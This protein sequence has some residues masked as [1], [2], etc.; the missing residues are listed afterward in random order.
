MSNKMNNPFIKSKDIAKSYHHLPSFIEHLP[1]SDFNEKHKL[2]LLEDHASLGVCFKITPLSCEARPEKMLNE[3]STAIGEA[4]KNAI[5]C[6]K[7]HPWILQ[8]YASKEPDL[9]SINQKI[10]D[11]FS[12]ERKQTA[13]T[14]DFLNIMNDHLEYVTKPKGI[15]FDSQVTNLHFRGGITHIY[16]VL[17]R[18]KSPP[19]HERHANI[20]EILR[21]ARKFSDQ[22]R[23]CGVGV[24]RLQGKDFYIW[25]SK[26]FN[27]KQLA[28][29]EY[30]NAKNIHND[31]AEQ[32]F[33]SLPQSFEEGWLFDDMP[34]KVITIQ[35]M[36][37]E[38]AIGHITA[39]RKRNIDDKIF[40]LLDHLPEGSVFV[41]TIV[42]Q[43]P[44]EVD[45]HLKTIHSS[46]VGSHA[47]AVKVKEE[48]NVAEKALADGNLLLPVVM[49]VY[50]RSETLD[51]L[52]NT[53]ANVEV[54]LN[55]NG[56]KVIVDDEL[57]PIDAYIRY[58][59]MCYDFHFDKKNS[60]RS[61]YFLLNDISKLLPFYGRSRGTANPGLV[62]FN[63]GGEPWFYDFIKDKTKNAHF[64]LLGES[65][66]GKSNLLCFI[67]TYLLAKYFPRVFIIDVGGSFYLLGEYCKSLGLK[68]NNIKVDPKQ[69]V[70]LNPFAN[71]LRVLNQ[72]EALQSPREK[73]IH[74]S[75][76]KL[77]QMSDDDEDRDIL[78]DMVLAAL[79]MVTGGEKREEETIRRSDRMMIMDAIIDAAYR[80]REE[81]REQMIAQDIVES[82]GRLCTQ[83]DADRDAE[84]IR[85]AREMADSMR[86]FTKDPMASQFFN[87]Y[88]DPWADA[89]LTIVD[90]A[91]FAREGYEA[92]RSI[93]FSGCLNHI[94]NLADANQNSDRAIYTI[95]D[96]NHIF[97]SIP[98]LAD[99]QTRVAK[100]GRKLG[101][102]LG[103]ATQNMKDFPEGA[104][105]MLA[106]LEHWICLSL[107]M[108]EIS[109]IEAFKT[110]IPE[111]RAM[112]LSARK[113]KG[114]YT[115][116]V[117]FSALLNSL[118]RHSPPPFFLALA[119][120]EQDEKNHRLRLM[121]QYG[122]T[123][124]EAVK[125][126]ANEMRKK[127]IEIHYDD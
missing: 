69:P 92:H 15:Y 63:R 6:E 37:T 45:L 55:S 16:A 94:Q 5:P 53:E 64:L 20:E 67:I 81:N 62:C 77:S 9:S 56:F 127:K 42:M 79:L 60:Y 72:I 100:T 83:L 39:E 124:I 120:T 33:F 31:L 99:I 28:K 78:G 109:Q 3:I 61:R 7:N 47:Q 98:L 85:R 2:F 19:S 12:S 118:F 76:E 89:D 25:M 111:Q 21:I 119:A 114:K 22:L 52:H 108:A 23:A 82:L 66:T 32:L 84:K 86:Y 122:C 107:P 27:P 36:T 104:K 75:C 115:E 110:L 4:I 13:I 14:Q 105:R 123:E 49:N 1:W 80:V 54:L 73:Y 102:W 17:Y 51:D 34:H 24:K 88:G 38:P 44:S 125:M 70:S 40:N 59:P 103:I 90:F 71:G 97:T 87:S 30:P 50:I 96:E 116:G 29:F 121:Q 41:M 10:E 113:E 74:E 57:F 35:S 117:I 8:V 11:C 43:A 48:I 65:G 18:R 93:A 101:L 112:L 58:L 95:I 26:W 106:Q 68:V 46:A 91:L 126:I